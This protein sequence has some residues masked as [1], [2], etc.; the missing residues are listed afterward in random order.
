MLRFQSLSTQKPFKPFED[1]IADED[2]VR[3]F[4][5]RQAKDLRRY[6]MSSST[7]LLSQTVP[8]LGEGGKAWRNSEG[9]TL[10]DFGVDPDVEFHDKDDMPLADLLRRRKDAETDNRL[11]T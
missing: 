5:Q 7:K 11:S 9:E 1:T 8:K 6:D 4:H 3:A 10:D 2:R